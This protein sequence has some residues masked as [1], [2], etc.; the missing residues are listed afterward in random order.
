[1]KITLWLVLAVA[2]LV[3][4]SSSFVIDDNTRQALVSVATGAITLAC[5]VTLFVKREKRT[6]R[7]G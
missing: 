7:S 2:L 3:N 6:Q 1:M 4:V 5:G